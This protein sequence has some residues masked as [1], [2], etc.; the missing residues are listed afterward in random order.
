MNQKFINYLKK[1]VYLFVFVGFGMATAGSYDD[2]FM[3]IKQ[4]DAGTVRELLVRG[5]DANTSD[6]KG[7]NGLYLALVEPSPKVA[8]VLIDWPK[9]D[10]NAVNAKDESPLMLAA[11]KGNLA[12]AEKLIAKGADTNKTGWT[13]LHYA[14]SGGQLAIISLLLEHSAYIDAESPNGTTPLMMA[15]MYGTTAAVNLLLR[16]G[17]DPQLKNQQGLSALQFAQRGNRPD[18]VEAIAASI[19]SKRPAGQW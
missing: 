18:A 16:E 4:D 1:S 5:F 13:P 9:T 3:A 6:P 12:L 7:Q 19:R 11:L 17:A 2:F 14:A 15:A 8:Q 10:V